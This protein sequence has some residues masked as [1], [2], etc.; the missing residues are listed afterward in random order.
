MGL[1]ALR[2]SWRVPVILA[3]VAALLLSGM[4]LGVALRGVLAQP[5]N[6]VIY[7]CMGERSG[8]VRIVSASESCLR[9]ELPI[10]W[11]VEGPPGPAGPQ[12]PAGPAGNN[13]FGGFVA[14]KVTIELGAFATDDSITFPATCV[15]TTKQPIW[16]WVETAKDGATSV[17][18]QTT[19]S[20]SQ[21]E[22]WWLDVTSF[23][24]DAAAL[25]VTV[26]IWCVNIT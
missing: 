24:P 21:Y 22:E 16:A 10:H 11:N 25:D 12:G 14:E 23:G 15:D 9:G 13:A 4:A 26:G 19:Q 3:S 17:D 7:A 20:F 18:L 1:P 8:A 5:S 6:G 2:V